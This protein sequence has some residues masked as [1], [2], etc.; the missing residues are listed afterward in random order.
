MTSKTTTKKPSMWEVTVM[1][2]SFSESLEKLLDDADCV[3]D[4]VQRAYL[5]VKGT[6]QE[7]MALCY[8]LGKTFAGCSYKP[9]KARK[10]KR[11]K[12]K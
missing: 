6:E 7:V 10:R 3:I 1:M 8:L 11:R 9:L 5:L 4:Y 12:G 2:S